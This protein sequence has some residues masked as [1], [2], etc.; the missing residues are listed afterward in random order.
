M[1]KTVNNME[2]NLDGFCLDLILERNKIG[3]E[4]YIKSGYRVCID[5]GSLDDGK[6]ANELL[7]YRKQEKKPLAVFYVDF[8]QSI[9]SSFYKTK[10]KFISSLDMMLEYYLSSFDWINPIY[11]LDMK[12]EELAV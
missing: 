4:K 2:Q 5:Y 6:I 10:D 3:K 8:G 9:C 1:H 12:E 7:I 11:F